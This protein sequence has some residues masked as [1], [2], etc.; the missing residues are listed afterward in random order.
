MELEPVRYSR[1]KLMAKS[2]AHY[3]AATTEETYSMERGTAV[4][5]LV[6]ETDPV[7]PWDKLSENGNPCPRKGKDFDKFVADNPGAIILT[8]AEHKLAKAQADAVRS[9]KLAMRV[10]DGHRENEITFKIGARECAGRPDVWTPKFVT[11]LKCTVDASPR[12]FK[13]QAR[14][15]GYRGQVVW[16]GDGLLSTGKA[17]PEAYFIVAVE[18]KPPFVVT[19]F[20]LTPASVDQGRRAY[21]TWFEQLMV[22]EDTNDFPGYCSAVVPLESDD[23]DELDFGGVA[24][25]AAA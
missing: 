14:N 4:H 16:Y 12:G 9:N 8:A 1:L 24:E 2:P 15:L 13:R 22:C 23:E 6:L 20:R 7:L 17:E 10:L 21:R 11:E 18:Q 19:V 25:E 5:S 3:L